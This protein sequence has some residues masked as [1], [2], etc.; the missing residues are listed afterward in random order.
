[1]ATPDP[2][3]RKLIEHCK[4]YIVACGVL[5][6][7][8]YE[9]IAS[10]QDAI[11]RIA[12]AYQVDLTVGEGRMKFRESCRKAAYE[13][14]DGEG[15]IAK[16]DAME[17][18]LD[19]VYEFMDEVANADIKAMPRAVTTLDIKCPY[20]GGAI[21]K[22]KWGYACENTIGDKCKFKVSSFHDKV[23]EDDIKELIVNG[24]TRKIRAISKSK[25]TENRL[26]QD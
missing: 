7:I 19:Y 6:G 3:E 4:N 22:L 24:V 20:C 1:M 25:K 5:R 16:D 12:D 8:Q 11:K 9:N 23:K 17:E 15:I 26:M 21:K 13:Y 14:L 10:M 2:E 18:I